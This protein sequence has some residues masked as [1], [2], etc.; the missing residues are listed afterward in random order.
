MLI[1]SQVD[2]YFALI[3]DGTR[4][5]AVCDDYRHNRRP[6]FGR[7]NLNGNDMRVL[8][9]DDVEAMRVSLQTALEAAGHNVTLAMTG[10]TAINH[11]RENQ[12]DAAILDVWMPDGDG[13]GV[14][15]SVRSEQPN[16]RIFMITGGGPRLPIEA[17]ALISDVWGA[18]RVFVKPFNEADLIAA[19]QA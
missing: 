1:E 4:C 10:R 6:G 11:L 18:E 3:I 19:L 8:V 15:K 17:A 16:L 2:D 7:F 5:L 12:F 13:L 9:A 14:L